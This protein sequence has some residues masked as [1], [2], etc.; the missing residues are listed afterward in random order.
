[1]S[2]HDEFLIHVIEAIAEADGRSPDDLGY[3]L[4]DYVETDAL[5]TLAESGHTDWVLTL[6]VPDHSVTVQGNGK[7][8]VDGTVHRESDLSAE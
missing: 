8:L 6:Q 1:M 2:T 5:L 4:Y 3:S 7:I